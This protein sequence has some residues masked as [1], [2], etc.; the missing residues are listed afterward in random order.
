MVA[1]NWRSSKSDFSAGLLSV[2]LLPHQG[3]VQHLE[4]QG[5]HADR[6]ALLLREDCA[7][8]LD[9]RGYHVYMTH[10]PVADLAAAVYRLRR[11]IEWL[12]KPLRTHYRLDRLPTRKKVVVETLIY[13]AILTRIVSRVLMMAACPRVPAAGR[14]V[15][16]PA[17]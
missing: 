17:A 15:A 8:N 7:A 9:A 6:H 10:V 4:R 2:A 13:A 12:F 14:A 3:P 5:Y 16:S 1:M 11:Q